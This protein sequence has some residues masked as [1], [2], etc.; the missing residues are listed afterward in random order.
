MFGTLD[1]DA[2]RALRVRMRRRRFAKG[3]VIFH[4]GDP[5]DAL[6]LIEKGHVALKIATPRGDRATL[7]VL[8]PEDVLGEFAIVAPAPRAATAIALDK[9]ETMVLDRDAFEQL[10]TERPEIDDFMLAAA[11]DEVRRVSAA[12]LEALYLPVDQR[13]CRRLAEL[14]AL[15]R[16]GDRTV[17]PVGQDDLAQL[18]GVTR[19]TV[20]RVLA[21]A[22]ADGVLA[23][24]RGRV[25]ILD[26]D[27]LDARAR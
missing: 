2:R 27:A 22:Q 26:T 13:V 23:I 19:Q 18:A 25:E 7:R 16:S 21:K 20:N 10:R 17:V 5:G 3:E 4:E 1:D 11:I 6:H 9:V 15:Y 12:L 14:A 24:D 8:G